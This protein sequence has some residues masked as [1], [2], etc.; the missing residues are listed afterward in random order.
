METTPRWDPLNA[1]SPMPTKPQTWN[2]RCHGSASPSPSPP[3]S[4]IPERF[5]PPRGETGLARLSLFFRI[6]KSPCHTRYRTLNQ[7]TGRGTSSVK[8]SH[9]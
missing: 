7:D 8:R 6:R 1:P 9:L 2:R 5:F 4:P 3:D